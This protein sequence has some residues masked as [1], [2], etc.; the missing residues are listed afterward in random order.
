[1]LPTCNPICFSY[2]TEF[3]LLNSRRIQKKR[4]QYTGAAG[5]L[6]AQLYEML[7]HGLAEVGL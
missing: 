4:L 6:I 2:V 3:D 7:W 5:K 1:M